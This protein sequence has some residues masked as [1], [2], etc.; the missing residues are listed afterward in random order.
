MSEFR[1]GNGS[2]WLDLLSTLAG[3]YRAVQDDSLASPAL[4]REWLALND[5][6]PA[7]AVTDDDL[8]LTRSVREALHRVTLATMAGEA[9]VPTDVA[10][11]QEALSYD[12]PPAL[13]VARSGLVAGRPATAREALARLVREAVSVLTGHELAHLRHCGDDMCSSVFLDRSGRRRWCTDLS[14]GNRSRVRAHRA[15]SGPADPE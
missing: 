15:R 11:L 6:E 10:Q 9:P 7:A 2:A 13:S 3:R 1:R 12:A 5:L 14:C 8:A 4:L